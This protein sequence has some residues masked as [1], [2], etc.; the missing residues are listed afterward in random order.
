MR[1]TGEGSTDHSPLA[2]LVVVFVVVAVIVVSVD[3]IVRALHSF[4]PKITQ[5][6]LSELKRLWTSVPCA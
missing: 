1:I 4:R 6:W 3:Q 2:F 5:E